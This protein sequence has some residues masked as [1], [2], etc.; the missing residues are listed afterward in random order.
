MTLASMLGS[1]SSGKASDHEHASIFQ[2]M[3]LRR[4]AWNHSCGPGTQLRAQPIECL[5][6]HLMLTEPHALMSA[7][8]VCCPMPTLYFRAEQLQ[9]VLS[10]PRFAVFSPQA[11]AVCCVSCLC[12]WQQ[13]FTLQSLIATLKS[14][15]QTAASCPVQVGTAAQQAKPACYQCHDQLKGTE[16]VDGALCS[17]PL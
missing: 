13:H 3:I 9:V 6:P 5:W 2:A 15:K 14:G 12:L 1:G 16:A 7:S 8:A 4:A 11:A 17:W 10:R